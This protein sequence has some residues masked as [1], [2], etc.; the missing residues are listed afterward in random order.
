MSLEGHNASVL[1][2]LF[3]MDS[4]NLFSADQEGI[5]KVWSMPSGELVRTIV[6]HSDLIQDVSIASDNK[7]LVS[8][9]LDKSVK[10]WDIST[11]ENIMKMDIG[12]EVWSVDLVSDA[13]TIVIGCADGSV[14]LLKQTNTTIKKGG[15]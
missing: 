2:V 1:T 15:K 3:S 14:R 5:I 11:G 7:T 4:K 13:S 10:M 12:T 9:S 8:G 6:A